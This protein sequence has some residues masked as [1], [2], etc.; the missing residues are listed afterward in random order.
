MPVVFIWNAK[1]AMCS[2]LRLRA[3]HSKF[4]RA[5]QRIPNAT[6]LPT[7]NALLKKFIA[8]RVRV[9]FHRHNHTR[10][11]L[12]TCVLSLLTSWRRICANR[13]RTDR[14]VFEWGC[15][16]VPVWYVCGCGDWQF[17][18]SSV[19]SST[20]HKCWCTS[21]ENIQRMLPHR[22]SVIAYGKNAFTF[23]LLSHKFHIT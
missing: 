8:G 21:A 20:S 2:R 12:Q 1:Y 17:G 3:S 10:S 23:L 7:L 16:Y 15:V 18:G 22:H 14:A 5:E 6:V 9:F 11:H 4:I 19:S 13:D